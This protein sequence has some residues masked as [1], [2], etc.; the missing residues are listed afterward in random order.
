MKALF[1]DIDGVL[2]KTS[3][4]EV[5]LDGNGYFRVNMLL[6]ANL[7]T[8]INKTAAKIILS[9][10]WRKLGGA[11][12]FLDTCGFTIFDITDEEGRFRGHEIQRWLDKHPEVTRYA[13]VDDD[14]D[15]LDPQ[16]RHF[17]QTEFE[18]GLTETIAYRITYWLN[19]E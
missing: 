7:K 15:M 2:N 13:I 3:D 8:I 18:Y 16:L 14:S 6:I 5:K 10:P 1:L 9:S 17:F 11:R 4:Y 19:H 12:E